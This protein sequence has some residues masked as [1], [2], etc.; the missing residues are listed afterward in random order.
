MILT[1]RTISWVLHKAV[2]VDVV[3]ILHLVPS[4]PL[5]HDEKPRNPAEGIV[6]VKVFALLIKFQ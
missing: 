2:E 4:A 5:I 1:Y 6:K 3:Q